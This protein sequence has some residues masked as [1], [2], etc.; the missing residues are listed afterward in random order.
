MLFKKFK[1]QLQENF[2]EFVK[3]QDVLYITNV[4]KDV[5]WDTYLASFP[6]DERQSF[7]CNSCKQFLRPYGNVVAIKDNKLV[8][9]WDFVVN[10][11]MAIAGIDLSDKTD[12]YQIV[13]N[14]LSKLVKSAPIVNVFVSKVKKLGTDSNIEELEDKSTIRWEHFHLVLPDKFVSKSSDSEETLMSNYRAHKEVFKRSLDEYTIDSINTVLELIS[15][16]S[17]YRG[18][19]SK[20]VLEAFLK[21]KIAYDKLP[22]NKKDNYTWDNSTKV[23]GAISK[24]RNNAIGTL[25]TDIAKDRDLDQAVRAFE[26]IMAPANYMRPNAIVTKSMIADAQ[27]KV[28]EL[29]LGDSLGRRYAVSDDITVNNVLFVDREKA[30]TKN[31]FEQLEE[32]AVVN[33]KKLTKVEEVSIDD[34]IN[35]IIPKATGLEFLFENNQIGNLASLIAPKNTE[36]PSLFKWNNGFSWSYINNVTD[37]I[38]ESVKNAGGKV[39]GVL[40]FSIEW[41][42]KGNNNIDF[43]AH[44]IEPNGNEIYYS[45][46]YRRDKGDV[47]TSMSGQLDIDIIS[48]N[49][50]VA[51]ENI[52]WSNKSKMGEGKYKFFVNNYS[53]STSNGGFK[54]EVEYD[55]EIYTFDYTS[56]LR[57]KENVTVME[58]TFS[59]ANGITITKS[60][61]GNSAISSKDIWGV[62][63]NKFQKVKMVMVSPNHWDNQ[64]IGNKHYFFILD[65]CKNNETSRGFYNEFLQEE[66]LKQK[67]VFEALGNKMVVEHSDQQLSGVGFS[68]TNRTQIVCKV[69][70]SITRI[71]KI[72]I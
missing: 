47:R 69:I 61:D 14:N 18:E 20:G 56:N 25:L 37:S 42:D 72:N 9:I 41:N 5:I 33:P 26:K 39:D 63:T 2:L 51:Y 59:K 6:E 58:L 16:N 29:G 23:S 40:R 1:Q 27:K 28:E 67:R 35:K 46:P 31:V 11:E 50:K 55:G 34:F 48:P 43:D 45:S 53:S 32:E 13:A 3:G 19:E 70:G 22:A 36:A 65:N 8:S 4:D 44:A 49:G 60:L 7:N 10:K 68:T 66:L 71:I 30:K 15:Q 52:C 21:Y 64:I 54:A 57:G 17:L 62:S 38:K 12:M 24:L